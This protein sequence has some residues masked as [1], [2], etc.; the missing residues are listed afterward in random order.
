MR[1][2]RRWG[3]S[4][5]GE[6]CTVRCIELPSFIHK[7]AFAVAKFKYYN[8]VME[9]ETWESSKEGNPVEMSFAQLAKRH[10]SAYLGAIIEAIDHCQRLDRRGL[11]NE[12]LLV[13]VPGSTKIFAL[14]LRVGPPVII[15]GRFNNNVF[16]AVHVVQQALTSPISAQDL[17]LIR[18][19]R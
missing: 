16:V 2:L 17:Q 7:G 11:K 9:F 14:T 15:F 19:R 4:L 12:G 13:R 10:G 5:V 1:L 3:S 18:N 8:I 6:I